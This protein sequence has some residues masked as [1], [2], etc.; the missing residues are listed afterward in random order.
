MIFLKSM[1]S[2]ENYILLSLLV[3]ISKTVS[4]KTKILVEKYIQKDIIYILLF[5]HIFASEA[6]ADRS[7]TIKIKLDFA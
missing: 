5:K 6:S 4:S 1:I 7:T 3:I 2:V